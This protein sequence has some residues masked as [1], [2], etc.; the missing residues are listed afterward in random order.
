MFG[1][2]Q[3]SNKKEQKW[4]LDS[5]CS[6]HMSGKSSL[7]TELKKQA[8]GSITL[9]DKG[10][11]DI[12][13]I[14]KVGS[15]NDNVIED[16]YLVDGLKY[17]LLSISQLCDKDNKVIFD[18]DKCEVQDIVSGKTLLTAPRYNNVYA[19]Y[20][21]QVAEK[22]LKCLKALTEDPRL[23]HRRLGHI[24]MHTLNKLA[25]KELVRGLPKL[26]I[27]YNE[28]CNA[29]VRGKHT[30]SS[31]K[32]KKTVSTTRPIELLHIDLCGPMRI[33]SPK[34]KQYILVTVDDYSRYTW[35]SFLREKSEALQEFSKLCKELQTLKNLPI[36]S[37]RSDHGKEFDF[38]KFDIFCSKYGISH[39]FSAPRT[40]QQ[41]GVVERKNRTLEDMSRTM[42]L[43]NGLPKYFWAEAVNTANYILN[44]CLIRPI[45]KKTPYELFR[46]RKPQI[47]YFKPFGCNCFVHN[48]GKD[49]LGKFDARSDP[50]IFLGYALNSKAYRIFNKRTKVVEESIH[51][52]FDEKDNGALSES[53]TG[54]N[55]NK[56]EGDDSDEGEDDGSMDKNVSK[57]TLNMQE[58]ICDVQDLDDPCQGLDNQTEERAEAADDAAQG[59]EGGLQDLETY[60]VLEERNYRFKA[61]HPAENLLSDPAS[62]IQTRSKFHNLCILRVCFSCRTKNTH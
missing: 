24:N 33:K 7:F 12:I 59:L 26:A 45:L 22:N 48:N 39:N 19:M 38:L 11:C 56:H 5:G 40:P 25:T 37:V 21:N 32:P 42:L 8:S 50:A 16:V 6:R 20:T 2:M 15:D 1:S 51:V 53:F 60:P 3:V 30:R 29:C 46:G 36:V 54:L 34:G 14:G 13:G 61:A 47:S 4:I 52:I 9:G 18:K 31:F 49:N 43:E 58:R 41:N 23:W 57:E 28:L 44:R 10:K 62:G 35:V 17:N 55:L 27:N